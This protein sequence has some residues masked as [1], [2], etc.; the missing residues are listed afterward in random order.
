[1][2]FIC[3]WPSLWMLCSELFP[4]SAFSAQFL[5]RFSTGEPKVK[6]IGSFAFHD[7]RERSLLHIAQINDTFS[8]QTARH[9]CPVNQNGSV[10]PQGM[11]EALAIVLWR[12]Q[13]WPLEFMILVQ[14]DV[15]GN[16]DTA[17]RHHFFFNPVVQVELLLQYFQCLAVSLPLHIRHIILRQIPQAKR[18][19]YLMLDHLTDKGKNLRQ[20]ALPIGR[21]LMS[22]KAVKGEIDLTQRRLPEQFMLRLMNQGS[23]CR[24]IDLEPFLVANIQQLVDFRVKER[25]P[26]DVQINMIGMRFDLVQNIGERIQLDK[27]RLTAGLRAKAAGQVTDARNLDI[28]F[29]KCFQESS[30]PI[31]SSYS[32]RFKLTEL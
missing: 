13:A 2:Q 23:V 5:N 29:F 14:V 21:A 26:F 20:V 4:I 22:I 6:I 30:N 16:F 28:Y 19:Q 27:R 31:C 17:A 7:F 24:Q 11:A 1:M 18:D 8:V 15:V 32:D 12:V 3:W 9:H 10:A 25:L